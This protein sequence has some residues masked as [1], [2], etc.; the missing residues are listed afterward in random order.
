MVLVGCGDG[1]V[2]HTPRDGG[3]GD[4]DIGTVFPDAAI[5]PDGKG[6]A[7][8]K[9]ED[10]KG[11]VCLN[12]SCC[13]SA[14]QVCGDLCCAAGKACFANACVTP[15]KVCYSAGD[16][17]PGQYCEPTL[18]PNGGSNAD[19]GVPDAGAGNSDAGG[20]G[21]VCLSPP[22]T[23]GRCLDLPERCGATP[24]PGCLPTCEFKPT[25]AKTLDA[26]QEWHWGASNVKKYKD[27]VDVWSTPVVGR[28]TDTNC[29]GKVNEL[30]PPNII[31][32]AGDAKGSQCAAKP[33]ACLEG[34]LRVLDGA[35]GQEIWSLRKP[36]LGTT[37]FSA[38]TLALGDV[39]RDGHLEIVGVDSNA[40]IVIVDYT[41][42][43]KATSDK[44][45]PQALKGDL[46]VNTS[47][48]WG[49][50][51]S[52]ADI[53]GDGKVEVA[54]GHSLF[55]INAK[56][57]KVTFVAK[58]KG[59]HGGGPTR[60]LSSFSDIN[61]DGKQEL[62]VGNSAYAY[63]GKTMTE[64]W[65]NTE[66]G[67][68][69]TAVADFDGD[70]KPEVALLISAANNRGSL[71]IL[72]GKTGKL[73]AGPFKLPGTGNGGPP[74]VADFDGALPRRPEIGVAK[75]N[76]YSVTKV[77]LS[78]KKEADKLK[79][80]WKQAN[81]DFSSSVTGSTVFDFEGDGAAEVI[82][83]DEC[84]I[85]VY[86]GKT[87]AVKF[88]HPT[89]SFTATEASL[90]ADVDGDGRAEMVMIANRANPTDW[91]CNVTPWTTPD[92]TLNRPAWEP[93]AGQTAWS[94][95]TVFGGKGGSWVGTRTLWNQHTY[96]VSNICDSRDSA[97]HT[98]ENQYGVIPAIEK[99]NFTVT[100][101][102]NYRQNVQDKGIFDAP[103]PSLALRVDCQ[104]GKSTGSMTLRSTLRNLGLAL[105][106][107]GVKV[108]FFVRETQRE[109]LLGEVTTTSPLFPGQAVE[110]LYTTKAKDGVTAKSIFIAK[111][112][113]DPNTKTFNEC[114]TDNNTSNPAKNPC[115]L[116]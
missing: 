115:V 19:G 57:T 18:G 15:G 58:G 29:D 93:P 52:L 86:D 41:G 107:A 20:A 33:P 92:P 13:A 31:V 116:Q 61:G 44:P 82:Y 103:D 2:A 79:L 45:I 112:L 68:G 22:P 76:Y 111:I 69:Y 21:Q 28:L 5:P 96:H 16:C 64:L 56:G 99:T 48:G 50:G 14:D 91:K 49:G 54:Y 30:D 106:P 17:D 47:F 72:Q 10:C 34:V 7:C 27:Y 23:A 4:R 46:T 9:N 74:T 94:G 32:I 101:L 59:G 109:R 85:W 67:D 53:N 77:D 39:D 114:R 37:G 60:A 73:L 26:E 65:T 89:T 43:L 1:G 75:A 78:A 42:K 6:P 81:H 25:P 36:G 90:V 35:S 102:N 11:G 88:A 80:L 62:L 8:K 84:F 100:W 38:V 40:H 110:L 51:L 95:I 70:G 97:C 63:D 3:G 24:T 87:G 66:V 83:N 108:G 113:I 12:G 71:A 104:A 55:T 98:N 105:L